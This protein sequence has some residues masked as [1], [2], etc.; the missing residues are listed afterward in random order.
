MVGES[1]L[2]V[3]AHT[4]TRTQT[5]IV[6]VRESRCGPLK[7]ADLRAAVAFSSGH[8]R[9]DS[10]K[11]LSPTPGRAAPHPPA[12]LRRFTLF[13]ARESYMATKCLEL[14]EILVPGENG[15][16]TIELA[17]FSLG[18]TKRSALPAHKESM[19][20]RNSCTFSKRPENTSLE[21]RFL[22]PGSSERHSPTLF[23][24]VSQKDSLFQTYI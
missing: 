3:Y 1:M 10:R 15:L 9:P 7:G 17:I 5:G 22:P 23:Q 18:S 19:G 8:E 21:T 24:P 12:E 2:L 16:N 14:G 6:R 20:P 4:N 11:R 13:W